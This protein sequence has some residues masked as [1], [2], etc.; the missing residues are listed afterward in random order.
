MAKDTRFTVDDFIDSHRYTKKSKL[1]EKILL[2]AFLV[3]VGCVDGVQRART[4]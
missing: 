3:F 1:N 4:G 2:Y